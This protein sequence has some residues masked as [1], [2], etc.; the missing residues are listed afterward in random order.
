MRISTRTRYGL[1]FMID[2]AQSGGEHSSVSLQDVARRQGI[3]RKYLWQVVTPLRG[4][5]LVNATRGAGG[6]YILT[7]PIESIT[8]R[9]IFVALEGDCALM[10]CSVAA[11][12]P[13][14][15]DCVARE[16]WGEV[17]GAIDSAMATITLAELVSRARAKEGGV[18]SDFSI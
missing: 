8:L 5:G 2:L 17:G 7:R 15:A 1:R 10:D 11:A 18:V 9:D 6:G 4:A 14:A 13:R 12:C 16:V 3:S